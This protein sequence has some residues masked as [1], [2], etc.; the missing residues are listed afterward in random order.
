MDNEIHKKYTGVANKLILENLS[1]LLKLNIPVWIRVP[2]IG[3]VNDNEDEMFK[4]NEFI[5]K[6]GKPQKMELL[7]YHAMGEH[8]YIA[9]DR[10][11]EKFEAPQKEKLEVLKNIYCLVQK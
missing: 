7:P 6:N 1:K 8:K 9:L 4:I 5:V 2:V 3:G 11:V 10:N